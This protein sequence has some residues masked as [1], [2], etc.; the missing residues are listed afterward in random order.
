MLPIFFR[1]WNGQSVSNLVSQ[2][3]KKKKNKG[4]LEKLT[5]SICTNILHFC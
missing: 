5:L 1:V 2:V 3:L 4:L